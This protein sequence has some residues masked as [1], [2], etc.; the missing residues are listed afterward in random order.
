LGFFNHLSAQAEKG[1]L[2]ISDSSLFYGCGHME[3][4][5]WVNEDTLR[6]FEC[7]NKPFGGQ[8]YIGTFG[9]LKMLGALQPFISG[10]SSKTINMPSSATQKDI[11][12]CLVVSHDL[13]IKCI[14][15]YRDGSKASAVYS[16]RLD[17]SEVQDAWQKILKTATQIRIQEHANPIRKKLP[18]RRWGQTVKFSI[19]DSINGFMTVGISDTGHCAEIFGRLGQGGSFINGMF[20]AFCKAFSIALQ[21]G[22]PFDDFISSFRYM[23]FD[24]A[25][26]VRIGEYNDEYKPDIHSCKSIVDLL[27]QLLDWMFPSENGRRLRSLDQG[28]INTL[29]A[30]NGASLSVTGLEKAPLQTELPLVSN[31]VSASSTPKKKDKA[32]E[33]AMVCPVCHSYAYVFDGKCRSCRDC[34]YKDGG[35]GA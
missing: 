26:W 14:A 29:F 22:V 19:G 2:P 10:A 4:I 7:A 15:I 30:G 16:T 9:H 31:T 25:G 8:R 24:P 28:Y 13:G 18:Y 3:G 12:E 11:Y 33:S 34:G 27:M 1:K 5:P 6:V 17:S 35:C 32:M 21:Y 20:D 23:S